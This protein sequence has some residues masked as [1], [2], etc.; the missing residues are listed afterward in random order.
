MEVALMPEAR[1]SVKRPWYSRGL[2][3]IGQIIVRM[4]ALLILLVVLWTGYT[5]IAYLARYVFR[6]AH[7][8]PQ[9]LD[10]L[11][12]SPEAAGAAGEAPREGISHYHRN[13]QPLMYAGGVGCTT[14]GCHT[15]LPHTRRKEVRAFTN[16]HTMF[17]DCSACH[18]PKVT[19]PVSAVWL[20]N[21]TGRSAQPPAL[22]R[23][24]AL[25]EGSSEVSPTKPAELHGDVIGFLR[26]AEADVGVDPPLHELLIQLETTEPGSPVWRRAIDELQAILPSRVRG[27]Y[28][29][30]ITPSSVAESWSERQARLADLTKEYN[31]APPDSP[32]RDTINKR[33][34]EQVLA[35]PD[36]C[37]TC[38]GGEPPRFNFLQLGYSSRR[39]AALSTSEVARMIQHIRE[40]RQFSYFTPLL[41][42]TTRGES[43]ATNPGEEPHETR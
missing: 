32:Q 38:H 2:S 35:K 1:P 13:P 27:E 14:S 6:P 21:D 26:Q 10:P 7:V 37:L 33:I 30:R 15:L 36:A 18:D 19:P 39:A 3:A 40:G 42:P 23:L 34:H 11:A 16:F 12:A 17:L 5:A 22:L 8:P 9:F 31:A 20:D 29:A 43:P 41:Q 25:F 24:L 28:G 4:Y